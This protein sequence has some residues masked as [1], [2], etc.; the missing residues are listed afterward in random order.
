MINGEVSFWMQQER[1]VAP[2]RPA[3][4][5]DTKADVCVV[6]AGFTG[7]WAAYRVLK[8][9]PDARVLVLEKEFAGYGASGRN[10]GWVS[11]LLSANRR[12][13]ARQAG[14]RSAVIRFQNAMFAAVDEI[15]EVLGTEGIG[16]D[17]RKVGH[18]RVA[19]TPAAMSRLEGLRKS[20]LEWGYDAG[21]LQLLDAAAT[22]ARIRV[23]GAVGSLFDATTAAVDPAKLVCGLARSVEA[24]GGVIFESTPVVSVEPGRVRLADGAVVKAG[25]VLVCTE[26]YTGSLQGMPPRRIVPVNSSLIV[27]PRLTDAQWDTIGWR[28]G[29]CF[30]DAAHV[31]TYGQRT[32]DGRIALGGRGKPYRFGSGTGGAGEVDRQ[33]VRA[34]EQR[35]HSYFPTLAGLAAEHAWCGVIGVTR[36]WCAFVEYDAESRVGSAGGYAGHG[37]TSAYVAANT[38]V[39]R[40]LGV[41]SGYAQLPWFGYRPPRWEPEPLRWAGI[42]GMYSLFGLADV[43]EE[44][45]AAG[46]TSRIAK[47]GAHFAGLAD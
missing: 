34:L 33:T 25:D 32:P 13:L 20:S 44:S 35:L 29:E 2:D 14:G 36:D 28:G 38:L 45:S 10:A 40:M 23:G 5:A 17:Q 6:G 11:A 42:R 16:A 46:T 9:R 30:G 15:L 18:L 41:Q 24:R 3:L 1:P 8:A 31:F 39:D 27:T 47:I 7:L 22:A 12:R 19:R 26:A 4:D 21:Q 37:V 43:R